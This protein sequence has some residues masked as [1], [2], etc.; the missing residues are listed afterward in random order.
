[1]SGAQAPAGPGRDPEHHLGRL[2]DQAQAP[3]T[4]LPSGA[5]P[6]A[7][8]VFS[9]A[10]PVTLSCLAVA[11]ELARGITSPANMALAIVFYG[12]GLPLPLVLLRLRRVAAVV[13]LQATVLL[14]VA[15]ANVLF[16]GGF[17]EP[18]A[19]SLFGYAAETAALFGS[20]GP[21]RGLQLLSWRTW[22][23]R[24]LLLF[25]VPLYVLL[26]TSITYLFQQPVVLT[27][28]TYLPP[29]AAAG[30]GLRA[31]RRPRQHGPDGEQ[32]A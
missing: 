13:S 7:L 15:C 31:I 27:L 32:P 8:A 10:A 23:L 5:W 14:A 11:W 22:A 18:F 4:A 9:I 21:R 29:L 6:D 19:F 26:I 30:L 24:V 28:L 20:A 3:A 16:R 17:G 2:A 25:A 12:L 1:M